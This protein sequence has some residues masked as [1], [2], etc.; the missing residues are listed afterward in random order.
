VRSVK[1]AMWL[2]AKKGMSGMHIFFLGIAVFVAISCCLLVRSRI[3]SGVESC[4]AIV[5]STP[6]S[7]E[8]VASE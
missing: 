7:A 2:V 8:A 5:G 4:L 3:C 6:A 1:G